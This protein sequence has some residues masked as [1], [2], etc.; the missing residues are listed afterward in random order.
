MIARDRSNPRGVRIERRPTRR[1][2]ASTADVRRASG[3]RV[4]LTPDA[5]CSGSRDRE[6][7]WT[8]IPRSAEDVRGPRRARRG[9]ALLLPVGT[10][11]PQATAPRRRALGGAGETDP[12]RPSGRHPFFGRG[13]RHSRARLGAVRLHQD[14]TRKA[15][16][17]APA[18]RARERRRRA[19]R[20][21]R[22]VG[23]PAEASIA[24][25]FGAPRPRELLMPAA[26]RHVRP[27]GRRFTRPTGSR[28]WPRRRPAPSA[29]SSR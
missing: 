5:G 24:S 3:R 26:I 23:A 22:G 11:A 12:G 6:R 8:R 2:A 25:R 20:R 9:R 7:R 27:R 1:P 16:E 21:A 28:S 10:R 29:R 14:V 17:D 4:T 19:R 18:R 13:L 15:V